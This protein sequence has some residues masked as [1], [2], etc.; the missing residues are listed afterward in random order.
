[1]LN[2][3]EDENQYL[4]KL[5]LIDFNVARHFR[6]LDSK[7]DNKLLLLTNTGNQNYQAPEIAKENIYDEKVDIWGVGCVLFFML[8]G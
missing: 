1:M 8:T 6:N 2:K 3:N 4:W 7:D 5:N